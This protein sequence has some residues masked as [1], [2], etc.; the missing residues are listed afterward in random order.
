MK[1]MVSIFLLYITAAPLAA[2][3]SKI[4]SE[5]AGKYI[6]KTAKNR[7]KK[8]IAIFPFTDMEENENSDTK[9]VT[10]LVIISASTCD[11]KV[12]DKSKLSKILNE[13]SLTQLGLVDDESAPETGKILGAD[14][15]IFGNLDKK[16]LQIRIVDATTGEILGAS[17]LEGKSESGGKA[18]LEIKK[19][20]P[21]KARMNFRKRRLREWLIRVRRNKPGLFLYVTMNDD[22]W[23]SFSREKPGAA[24]KITRKTESISREKKEKL[25]KIK[26]NIA[27]LRENDPRV[28]QMIR[29]AQ[30]NIIRR[31][32]PGRRR[33]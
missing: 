9:K 8:I 29:K 25:V 13:Q 24:E 32:G 7:N 27:L 22:E 21:G 14:T 30:K 12:V 26:K 11:I 3:D 18:K 33:R 4:L 17:N 6:C 1:L 15:L 16:S 31:K 19:E 20:D 10:T 28:D 2:V 5:G 23:K